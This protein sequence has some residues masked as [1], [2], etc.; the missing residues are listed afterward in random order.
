M[1]RT[2]RVGQRDAI[3]VVTPDRPDVRNAADDAGRP[4][5]RV[6]A[7]DRPLPQPLP[8]EWA[9]GRLRLGDA[10]EGAAGA[11]GHGTF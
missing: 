2:V 11:G 9:R 7:M 6:R 3:A 4:H 8:A 1:E 10:L 5:E